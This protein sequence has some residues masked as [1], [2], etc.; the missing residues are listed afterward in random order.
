MLFAVWA[1]DA[2]GML[3]TRLAVREAHRR[4]LREP[5]PHAVTVLLAGP[6]LDAA[7]ASMAGTL[8]VVDADDLQGVSAFVQDDPYVQAGVYARVEIRPWRCGLGPFAPAPHAE[9]GIQR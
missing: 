2:A 9:A 7:G 1:L 5:S 4:R 6:L 8:L 3:D